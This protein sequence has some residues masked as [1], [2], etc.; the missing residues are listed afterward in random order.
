MYNSDVTVRFLAAYIESVDWVNNALQD[1]S[2]EDYAYLVD[3]AIQRT[4]ITDRTVIEASL[5]SVIYTYGYDEELGDTQERPLASLE[6]SIADLVQNLN[7]TNR[8][9]NQG[10]SSPYEFAQRY[11]NDGYLSQALSYEKSTSGY[12]MRTVT[13]AVIAGDIHQIAV[14]LGDELGIFES[15]GI[16]LNISSAS[17]GAG[18]ATSLQNGEADVGFVGAPPMTTTVVNGGLIP[19]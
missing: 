12:S 4:G 8:L 13:V 1:K 11:V 17:N 5:D 19:A 18:V 9:S 15:Y 10:F 7:L 14:H 3:L 2:S 16:N 6:S